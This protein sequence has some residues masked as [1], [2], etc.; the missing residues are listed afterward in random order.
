M[1]LIVAVG[2][3]VTLASAQNM[4]DAFANRY[5]LP[6]EDRK[7]VA[8]RGYYLHLESFNQSE[9]RGVEGQQ[10]GAGQP[11]NAKQH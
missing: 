8:V 2:R 4:K 3:R 9:E 11:A 10:M 1:K 7:P 6:D 5:R